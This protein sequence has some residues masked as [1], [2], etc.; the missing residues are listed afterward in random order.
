[1]ATDPIA[2]PVKTREIHDAYFDSTRWNDFEVRDSGE[3]WSATYPKV[4]D[5]R[6]DP[7]DRLAADSRR[8]GRARHHD[9]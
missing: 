7:G 3:R 6:G 5:D 1:M 9:R 8:A 4:G 2:W